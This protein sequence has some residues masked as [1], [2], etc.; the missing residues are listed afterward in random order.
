VFGGTTE[1][2]DRGQ[3]RGGSSESVDP[4]YSGGVMTTINGGSYEMNKIIV[5][6]SKG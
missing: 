6:N 2:A 1:E 4:R 3:G 5:T